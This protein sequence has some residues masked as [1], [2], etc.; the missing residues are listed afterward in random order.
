MWPNP[1]E[2]MGLVTFT[3]EI[4][5]LGS[6]AFH[7]FLVSISFVDTSRNPMSMEFL[8]KKK[9]EKNPKRIIAWSNIQAARVNGCSNQ[10]FNPWISY[11]MAG[12][13]R[14]PKFICLGI[15]FS[16]HLDQ[17][18]PDLFSKQIAPNK[19]QAYAI[20]Y[21][22]LIFHIVGITLQGQI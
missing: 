18:I 7:L 10:L 21:L 3:E 14:S 2:S 22:S 16:D 1:Q 13:V 20:K 12:P 8:L 9:S 6:L 15:N 17:R 19:Y 5:S 4:V 11:S